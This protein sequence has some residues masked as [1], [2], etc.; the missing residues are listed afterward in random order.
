VIESPAARAL[1]AALGLGIGLVGCT[2]ED[3]VVR[4]IGTA[5]PFL[6]DSDLATQP[7]TSDPTARTIQVAEWVVARADFTID[8]VTTD[9]TFG[10][11][12]TF[13]DTALVTSR[14]IDPC[15]SGVVIA[16][17][18][19]ARPATLELTLAM[20]VRRAEP[21]LLLPNDDHD[22]DGV[23]NAT[24]NCVLIDNPDQRSS[25]GVDFGDACSV[26]NT[27]SGAQFLDSDRDGIA[28]LIDNCTHVANPEQED[29]GVGVGG[30]PDGIGDACTEQVAI[31]RV[32]GNPL[33]VLSLGPVAVLQEQFRATLLK[34]DF[35][36]RSA[37]TCD[38][39]AAVCDLD[40]G[41]I[42]FCADS[43]ALGGCS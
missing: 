20:T 8:G 34:V 41:A 19:V 42:E 36:S 15:A 4:Q 39:P 43:T 9:L 2:A 17:G 13:T 27:I 3:P 5:V 1:A 18:L 6:T 12:C 38:W 23:V 10:E 25:P 37:L 28:D 29:T 7:V 22:G 35:Q 30:I 11:P 40:P 21:L 14:G 16:S 32:Q 33:I 26:R 31:V 24:D